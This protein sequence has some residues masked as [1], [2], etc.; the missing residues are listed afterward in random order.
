MLFWGLLTYW[1]LSGNLLPVGAPVFFNVYSQDPTE[2]MQQLEEQGE[3]LE[4][5]REDWERIWGSPEVTNASEKPEP[6]RDASLECPS[7]SHP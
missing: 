6:P 3:E 5:I 7:I 4:A 1:M 2:R